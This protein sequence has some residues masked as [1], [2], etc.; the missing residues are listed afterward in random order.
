MVR[1]GSHAYGTNTASSDEDFKGVVIAPKE[2]YLGF[3][4]QFEQLTLSAPKPD[5]CVYEIRKFFSLAAA[6]NPN[7]IEV[8]HVDPEDRILVNVVG[9]KIFDNKDKFI[10]KRVR[11]TFA[12]YAKS[13]LARIE[14]H[15]KWL[16]NPPQKMPLRS[17][18]E[19]QPKTL[20]PM[21]QLMAVKAEINKE[22]ERYNLGF[23]DD[24]REDQ[25]IAVHNAM[26]DVLSE[27]K[28][29]KDD[30]WMSAARKIGMQE[31]FIAYMQKERQYEGRA[32]EWEQY[33]NWKAERN[34][35]RAEL[36]AKYGYDTKHAYHLV[37]LIRMCGEI[38]ETGRVIVKRPD[39]EE[40]LEIRN[41]AWT[42]DKLIEWA[43]TEERKLDAVCARSKIPAEPDMAFLERLC[44][45]II[46]M[47]L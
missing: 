16:L 6:C 22:L 7:I 32:R 37:R 38:L 36:E 25:T 31:N 1:H 41:G 19:L 40:L 42:Y 20:I 45:E 18:F 3:K 4:K 23:L 17:D 43:K 46:E 24:L 26:R 35:A 5:T 47:M 13:Q 27:L 33:N 29:T 14:T 15:R 11:F 9:E 34:E 12:G 30:Q 8:L 2:S 21:D 10:S 28:I 39:R 44:I